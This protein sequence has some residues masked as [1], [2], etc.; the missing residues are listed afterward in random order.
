MT[1]ESVMVALIT[2]VS[3]L[4]AAAI[5]GFFT[6]RSSGSKRRIERL[7]KSLLR[8]CMDILAFR[9]IEEELLNRLARCTGESVATLKQAVREEAK[10]SGGISLSSGSAKSKL[11]EQINNL[12][13]PDC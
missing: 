12:K 2:A 13:L 5:T 3:T 1:P 9:C 7:Q 10:I 6:R 4:G 8:R 11:V